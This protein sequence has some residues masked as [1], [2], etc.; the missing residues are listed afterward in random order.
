MHPLHPAHPY[1]N[2]HKTLGA[3]CGLR[4][5]GAEPSTPWYKNPMWL[6]AGVGALVYFTTFR[7]V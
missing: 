6:L 4:G 2:G 3:C 1:N 5:L 7:G